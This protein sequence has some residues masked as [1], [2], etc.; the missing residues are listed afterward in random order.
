MGVGLLFEGFVRHDVR[1]GDFKIL[2]IT[3]LNL[4]GQSYII[5]HKEKP[6]SQ[7]AQDLL[8]LLRKQRRNRG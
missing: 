5:Y 7:N 3:W 6:L 1:R 4:V 2:K 8:A